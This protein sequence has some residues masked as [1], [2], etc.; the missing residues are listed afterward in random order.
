M[1]LNTQQKLFQFQIFHD[2]DAIEP[3]KK[4][5]SASPNPTAS[6]L[7]AE[8]LKILGEEIPHRLSQNVP[9]WSVEDVI[10]WVSQVVCLK[11]TLDIFIVH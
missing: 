1:A 4:V 9:L 10:F 6:R 2:I 3:L 7:A 11:F 5:A 8:A